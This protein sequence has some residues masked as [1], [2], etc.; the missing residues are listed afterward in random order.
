MLAGNFGLSYGQ[1]CDEEHIRDALK[2]LGC[3]VYENN[4]DPEILKSLDLILTFKSNKV[5]VNHIRDWKS[6]TK[7]PIFIWSFD[8]MERFKW[9]YDIVEP[10]RI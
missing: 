3:I 8:N 6:K 9:F 2:E 1:I 5:G 7:A 4:N 10:S